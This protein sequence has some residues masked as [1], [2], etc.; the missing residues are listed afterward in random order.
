MKSYNEI[1]SD[2]TKTAIKI[3]QSDYLDAGKYRIFDQGKEYSVGFS[4]DEQGVVTDYPYI[5]FGDH[6]RVVKYVDEPCYIGADGVKLLKVIN[7][8]FD[9]RYVY[10]NILAKPIES[11]GY[12]RHFKFLK[13]IQ[14]TEKSFSE[15]QKIAAELDKIQSAIDNKKQQLSLLDEAVKSEFV[16]MFGNPIYN[17]K[18]FPTK[19][20]I[21]VVTMQRG[22]DLP[23]QDRD[24]KG[25]IPVFG[26]NGILGNHNLAKMDKGIITGRSGTIGEV[27]MCETPFWPLNTTLFSNDTHGNNICYLKFLL[28]FFDLKR[29]KSGVGVP[30]LNRNEFH[31][32]QIIDVPLD[33][34][35]QFAAF[36]QKI[37]KSKFVVKQQIT[38]LQ[39]LLDSK[40]Q[41]YFS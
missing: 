11:Q 15:Q 6:T 20:V 39:E 40:M 34:Q 2:V 28:E 8:D 13:E 18:N 10:Y 23:V 3:P 9:P 37:D 36:V 19:K 30:T 29:F 38:D 4:N 31:D 35:N 26:S 1:L 16:E 21:D 24:S 12:A 7:K 5:I 14:F 22:Y 41:E 17:S 32:E 33:L 25:K 27:Y